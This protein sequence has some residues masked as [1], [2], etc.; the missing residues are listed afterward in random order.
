M[1]WLAVDII[2]VVVNAFVKVGSEFVRIGG[3]AVDVAEAGLREPLQHIGVQGLTQT[4]VLAAIPLLTMIATIKL[5][6]GIFRAVIVLT[7]LGVLL[8]ITWPLFGQV[9][10]LV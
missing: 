4:L 7:M 6:G 8:R 10:A 5:L 1:R 2:A 9:A 3:A